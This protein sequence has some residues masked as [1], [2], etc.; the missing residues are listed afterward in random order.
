[1]IISNNYIW[2]SLSL[3]VFLD[4][5]K[6]KFKGRA[7]HSNIFVRGDWILDYNLKTNADLISFNE[8]LNKIYLKYLLNG[9]D[10]ERKII[11]F[12]NKIIDE[13]TL[14]DSSYSITPKFLTSFHFRK[15]KIGH[16]KQKK[17]IQNKNNFYKKG[18]DNIIRSFTKEI[19]ED[20]K[21]LV[22]TI[23]DLFP[24]NYK[25]IDEIP[26]LNF[27]NKIFKNV[28]NQSMKS[29]LKL[30]SYI[31]YKNEFKKNILAGYPFFPSVFGRDT[32]IA[33]FALVYYYPELVKDNIEFR[34]NNLGNREHVY[35][36]E[37]K[38]KALHEFPF[39]ELTN[40][41]LL[42]NFPNYIGCD[43]SPLLM[44]SILM[45]F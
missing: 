13:T 21:K 34:L 36:A 43:E 41:F 22:I 2:G 17:I 10:Y 3:R 35:T 40:A 38:G 39:D 1:M 18:L 11:Y 29:L 7:R 26:E 27:K 30:I 6:K 44:I 28:Y 42:K 16:V 15:W 9:K 8:Q 31:P 25:K 4:N 19:S 37:E 23:N 12:K 5:H 33:N 32:D 45:G 14:P 20:G 24:E